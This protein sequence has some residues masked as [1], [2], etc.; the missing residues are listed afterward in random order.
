MQHPS[1]FCSW[2]WALVDKGRLAFSSL[3]CL[4]AVKLPFS[5]A[6]F[7]KK[8]DIY[9][10]LLSGDLGGRERGRVY[11]LRKPAKKIRKTWREGNAFKPQSLRTITGEMAVGLRTATLCSPAPPPAP[12]L[13]LTSTFSPAVPVFPDQIGDQRCTIQITVAGKGSD[14]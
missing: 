3:F 8:D 11:C 10:S 4:T 13:I 12:F 2:G 1:S 5:K 6:T 9:Q 7:K 14:L